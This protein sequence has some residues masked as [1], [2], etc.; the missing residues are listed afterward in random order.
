M[1]VK[2]FLDKNS[3]GLDV[4]KVKSLFEKYSKWFLGLGDEFLPAL[5]IV[6]LAS[7]LMIIIV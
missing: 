2:T 5:I 7:I 4:E 3:F 6:K 1:R